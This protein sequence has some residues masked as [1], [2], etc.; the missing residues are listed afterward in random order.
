MD[1]VYL[2]RE[3]VRGITINVVWGKSSLHLPLPLPVL[4]VLPVDWTW[5][6]DPNIN[7]TPEKKYI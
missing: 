5:K 4:P 2:S 3:V 1:V 7:T 6:T